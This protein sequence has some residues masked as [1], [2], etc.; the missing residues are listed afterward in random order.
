MIFD[1]IETLCSR[2][3]SLEIRSGRSPARK[4]FIIPQSVQRIDSRTFWKTIHRTLSVHQDIFE[5][6]FE[7]G[8]RF[9]AST[10]K[11]LL[12]YKVVVAPAQLAAYVRRLREANIDLG[13]IEDQG[14]TNLHLAAITNR[15]DLISWATRKDETNTLDT[16][17]RTPLHLSVHFG[18]S[19]IAKALIEFGADVHLATLRHNAPLCLAAQNNQQSLARLLAKDVDLTVT[20]TCTDFQLQ[21]INGTIT[22]S[23]ATSKTAAIAT[24]LFMIKHCRLIDHK[25]AF[26]KALSLAH[27]PILAKR[28]YKEETVRRTLYHLWK[29]N[30]NA[31]QNSGLTIPQKL[32]ST[33][34]KTPFA[35]SPLYGGHQ[36]FFLHMMQKATF[37]FMSLLSP[38]QV[39]DRRAL[40]M[41]HTALS[42]A[43]D[44]CNYSARDLLIRLQHGHPVIL[45]VDLS[46][47]T[48]TVLLWNHY[49]FLC[50]KGEESRKAV[51]VFTFRKDALTAE[52][53]DR[54][55]T[56]FDSNQDYT[57]F[58]FTKLP[59]LLQFRQCHIERD[60]EL[61]LQT[62]LQTIGNCAWESPE[63][64]VYT[65]LLFSGLWQNQLVRKNNFFPVFYNPIIAERTILFQNWLLFCQLKALRK[66]LTVLNAPDRLTLSNYELFSS[67]KQVYHSKKR[68]P[69]VLPA[70]KTTMAKL[71]SEFEIDS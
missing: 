60:L 54:I 27:D 34:T 57:D 10:L 14:F 5:F 8:P 23:Q 39:M 71:E 38:G 42:M 68:A 30:W 21:V 6:Q 4:I 16:Q 58:F 52:T 33:S 69:W 31:G 67:V 63:T 49:F 32:S 62:P 47:H 9:I 3:T 44:T 22:K 46:D 70:L 55:R 13:N 28:Y 15:T 41:L 35:F 66:Y 2:F 24:A 1:P 40:H 18:H 48:A 26:E 50:N 17:G 51:E 19:E 7:Q 56:L 64:C 45:S 53:I 37:E 61:L 25:L 36:P 43:A 12:Q 11:S 29:K 65:F 59:Q 20:Q